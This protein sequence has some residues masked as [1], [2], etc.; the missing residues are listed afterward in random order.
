M[1]LTISGYKSSSFEK[2][3]LIGTYETQLNPS[4][5]SVTVG[6]EKFDVKKDD[7][8]LGNTMTSKAPIFLKKSL[9]FDFILD[10]GAKQ[11]AP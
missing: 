10:Q 11:I 3:S 5:L 2:S 6:Q 7:D 8:A 4:E 1:K 9:S